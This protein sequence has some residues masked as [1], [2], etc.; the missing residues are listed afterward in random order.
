MAAHLAAIRAGNY[1]GGMSIAFRWIAALLLLGTSATALAQAVPAAIERQLPSGHRVLQSATASFDGHFFILVALA[2]T[3]EKQADPD[4]ARPFLIYERRKDGS[5]A[6]AGR[7]DHVVL[8]ADEGGQ[9]DPFADGGITAKGAYF[10]V[11]N[12][13]ACGQH[14]TWYVTF[15]F[16]PRLKAYV[17]D[18]ARS[19]SWRPNPSTTPDADALLSDGQQVTRA[20]GTPV[21]FSDWQAPKN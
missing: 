5:F 18:N 15:R 4:P 10:T 7:N 3:D 12:V 8:R 16:D 2:R 11:E 1:A 19:E 21:R 6:L 20:K 9:C 13:V 14:W 17:F